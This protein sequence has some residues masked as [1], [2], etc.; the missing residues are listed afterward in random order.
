MAWAASCGD[1]F[2]MGARPPI[3]GDEIRLALARP[4]PSQDPST[5]AWRPFA[6]VGG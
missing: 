6:G 5:G 2:T 3:A 1:V 4:E